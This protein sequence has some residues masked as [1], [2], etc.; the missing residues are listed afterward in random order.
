MVKDTV[1]AK[2]M[3]RDTDKDTDKDTGTMVEVKDILIG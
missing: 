1:K 2:D 3:D